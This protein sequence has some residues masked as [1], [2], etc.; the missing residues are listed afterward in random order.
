[1]HV[2]ERAAL[3]PLHR[4]VRPDDVHLLVVDVLLLV[5]VAVFVVVPR[6]LV[7][8]SG[9]YLPVLV[10]P[11]ETQELVEGAVHADSLNVLQ[12]ESVGGGRCGRELHH[13][14]QRPARLIDRRRAVQQRGVVDEIRRD[15]REV[16]H[17][18]HRVV[19][20][21]SVPRHLRMR[22]SRAAERDRRERRP[23]VL[24]DEERGVER[25]HVGDRQGDVLLEC[26]RVERRPFDADLLHRPPA[27]DRNLADGDVPLGPGL[28]GGLLRRLRA[29]LG[30]ERRRKQQRRDYPNRRLSHTS[31]IPVISS[32]MRRV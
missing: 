29:A 15:H 19:D 4:I 17:T 28:R 7:N 6:G 25:Q 2:V 22:G 30:M 1:M 18:E 11:R 32:R 3:V 21:H 16:G 5:A 9:R 23:A 12:A 26:H 27:P 8:G 10:A 13:A 20:A 31:C 24:L 14:A